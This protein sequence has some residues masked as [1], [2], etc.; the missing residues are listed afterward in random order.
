MQKPNRTLKHDP[1][2]ILKQLS[3]NFEN[4]KTK[5]KLALGTGFQTKKYNLDQRKFKSRRLTPV[6]IV[7]YC[8]LL[9]NEVSRFFIIF[10]GAPGA[11]G[12]SGASRAPGASGASGALGSSGVSGALENS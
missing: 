4:L 12:A 1:G 3:V 6:F 11:S 5:I 10:P 9:F 8:L 7:C 2:R